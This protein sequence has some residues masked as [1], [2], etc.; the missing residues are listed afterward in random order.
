[1]R[2]RESREEKVKTGTLQRKDGNAKNLQKRLKRRKD[3]RE[4]KEEE[5]EKNGTGR[6]DEDRRKTEEEGKEQKEQN[7]KD[8][9]IK[10]R[11][12]SWKQQTIKT[13]YPET[14]RKRR[15]RIEQEAILYSRSSR[16]QKL[17]L[18]QRVRAGEMDSVRSEALRCV[19]SCDGEM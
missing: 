13:G 11:M 4:R 8:G 2:R 9:K 7:R 1:M 15:K 14:Q 18:D 10:N 17:P 19:P 3:K 6:K 12:M 5:D 16:G